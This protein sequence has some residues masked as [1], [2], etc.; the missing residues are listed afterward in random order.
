MTALVPYLEL[1]ETLDQLGVLLRSTR[2]TRRLS[3]RAAG[4][5]MGLSWATVA[6]IENGEGYAAASAVAVL[7]WLDDAW[8]EPAHHRSA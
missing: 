5:E 3:L 6:R 8:H 1:A 7:K 2:R 4:D